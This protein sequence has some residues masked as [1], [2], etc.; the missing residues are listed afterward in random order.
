MWVRF[1]YFP[2]W[3]EL[4]GSVIN[5]GARTDLGRRSVRPPKYCPEICDQVDAFLAENGYPK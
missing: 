2:E 5:P 4:S 3:G 1:G